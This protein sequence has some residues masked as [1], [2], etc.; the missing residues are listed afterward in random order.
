[1]HGGFCRST[2]TNSTKETTCYSDFPMPDD[3]PVYL[4]HSKYLEYLRLYAGHFQLEQHIRF[5]T[6]VVS[7]E[8]LSDDGGRW[9]VT[10]KTKDSTDAT[11]SELF[12][13][14]MVC[15][16]I[17]SYTNMPSFNGQNEFEGE[18]IHGV[19]YR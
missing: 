15:V 5:G 13:A 6:E 1:M 16:G 12:D 19:K 3:F 10:T 14:V 8:Q 11:M 4:P 18:L 17:N 2:V 7:L 9:S